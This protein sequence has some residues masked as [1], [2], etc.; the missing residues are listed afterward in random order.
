MSFETVVWVLNH[1]EARGSDR[2]VLVAL[3]SHQ[4]GRAARPAVS[5]LVAETLLDRRSVFRSLTRLEETK[6]I[7]VSHKGPGRGGTNLYYVRTE[8]VAEC[9]QYCCKGG[10]APPGGVASC[11]EK[12]AS[13]TPKGGVTPPEP[14]KSNYEPLTARVATGHLSKTKGDLRPPLGIQRIPDDEPCNPL[15]GHAPCLGDPCP[16]CGEAWTLGHRCETT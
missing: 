11:H 16:D 13:S 12:V 14:L 2:L 10:V 8:K 6:A 1:S 15:G 5:R 3:A 7:E 9:H 4:N